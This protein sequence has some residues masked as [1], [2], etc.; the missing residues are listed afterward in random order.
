MIHLLLIF[1]YYLRW[2]A[3]VIDLSSLGIKLYIIKIIPKLPILF[4][5]LSRL[6]IIIIIKTQNIYL[7]II[8]NTYLSTCVCVPTLDSTR[9]I[10]T[11]LISFKKYRVL[12][13]RYLSGYT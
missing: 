2:I 8:L 10:P 13:F 7:P 3:I 12:T 4:R 6:F 9:Y 11:H 5:Y 1:I